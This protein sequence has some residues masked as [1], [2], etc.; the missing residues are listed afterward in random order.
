MKKYNKVY[1]VISI[2]NFALAVATFIYAFV[3]SFL[4]YRNGVALVEGG[5]VF[6]FV[7]V[8]LF[9]SGIFAFI[10]IKFPMFSVPMPIL[11]F[12][13]FWFAIDPY[14]AE[15][16]YVGLSSK[17][18]KSEMASYGIGFELLCS[19]YRILI[20]QVPCMTTVIRHGAGRPMRWRYSPPC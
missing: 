2:I 9:V 11:S 13:S 8:P 20:I 10:A 16:V 12:A 5:N 14:L 6:Y 3:A 15:L 17:W 19:L 1:K 7:T 18:I 4:P